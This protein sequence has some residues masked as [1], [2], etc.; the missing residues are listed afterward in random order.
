MD[1]LHKS[2]YVG[3]IFRNAAW[4]YI[5]AATLLRVR[6]PHY[7][8]GFPVNGRYICLPLY[9]HIAQLPDADV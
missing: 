1:C 2:A 5:M 6:L 3:P 7:L 4:A 8:P 9:P